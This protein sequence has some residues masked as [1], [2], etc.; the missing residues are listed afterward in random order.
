MPII[1][2]NLLAGRPMETKQRLMKALTDTA[3]ATLGV[4][5]ETVRVIINEIPPEHWATGGVAKAPVNAGGE[6]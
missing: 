1:Q 2:V 4:P 5:V 6:S 3:V